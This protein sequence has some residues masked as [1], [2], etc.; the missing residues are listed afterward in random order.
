MENTGKKIVTTN[1][2]ARRDYFIE[3][4]WEAGIVLEGHE[5]K[6]LRSGETNIQD[7]F[8]RIV[9]NEAFLHNVTIPPYEHIATTTYDPARQRKLLLHRTEIKR[10]AGLMQRQGYTALC[11]EI[12]FKHGKAKAM[13]ALG[14]GKKIYDKRETIKR[15]EVDREV[16]RTFR[17]RGTV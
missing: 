4:Q 7:G 12:Y 8:V 17:G 6:S 16:R 9:N 5:V 15:R 10:I 14:K 3:D 13:I 2:K 11:L 1:H